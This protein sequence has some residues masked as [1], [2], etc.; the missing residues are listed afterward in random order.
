MQPQTSKTHTWFVVT[1]HT[2]HQFHF[3]CSKEW[4]FLHCS[5]VWTTS[6]NFEKSQRCTHKTSQ[7][8]RLARCKKV[9]KIM[10][11]HST[12]WQTHHCSQIWLFLDLLCHQCWG[13]HG[14]CLLG[15]YG[16]SSRADNLQ[17][18][19]ILNSLISQDGSPKHP[20]WPF[21]LLCT[22]FNS[23]SQMTSCSLLHSPSKWFLF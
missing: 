22:I 21:F 14:A 10:K 8:C 5:V 19:Q 3:F 16:T 20:R 7:L 1:Q 23:F 18:S 4:A 13:A 17:K 12:N 15:T 11:F 6:L 2:Q 9:E